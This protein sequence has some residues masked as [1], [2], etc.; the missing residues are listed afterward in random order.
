V[1]NGG[2]GSCAVG[3][4]T[5]PER[6]RHTVVTDGTPGTRVG[7]AQTMAPRDREQFFEC[8]FASGRKEYRFHCRAWDPDEAGAHF[9]SLLL[10]DGVVDPGTLMIRNLRGQVLRRGDLGTSP[11][12]R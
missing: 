12:P 3:R 9:R 1:G 2:E 7:S 6:A 11:T 8:T 10:K 5:V 4:F